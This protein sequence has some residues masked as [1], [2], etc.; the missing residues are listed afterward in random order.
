ML[1]IVFFI[2]SLSIK[3][4]EIIK[5]LFF[6]FIIIKKIANLFKKNKKEVDANTRYFKYS[7]RKAKS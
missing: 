5:I 3:P 6:P 2:L 7:F 4:N 1:T